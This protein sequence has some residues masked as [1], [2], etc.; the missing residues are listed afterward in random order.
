MGNIK[1]NPCAKSF[2]MPNHKDKQNLSQKGDMPDIKESNQLIDGSNTITQDISP[3]CNVISPFLE[4]SVHNTANQS[5]I[6]QNISTPCKTDVSDTT[7]PILSISSNDGEQNYDNAFRIL[8]D[9][10]KKYINNV[11]I[12][13]LN[14][15][16]PARP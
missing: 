8:N 12:R 15:N 5:P 11:V 10:R 9:V 1:L 4:E 6:I 14:I 16:S 2:I 13:H 7:N 3:P